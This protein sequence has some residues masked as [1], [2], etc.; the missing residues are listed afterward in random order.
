MYKSF[1]KQ[2]FLQT[3]FNKGLQERPSSVGSATALLQRKR[4]YSRLHR[5]ILTRFAVKEFSS[6][7]PFNARKKKSLLLTSYLQEEY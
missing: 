3:R 4:G 6:Y 5:G 2:V 7:E 1:Y